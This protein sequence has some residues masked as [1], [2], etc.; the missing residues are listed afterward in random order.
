MNR[1]GASG[2]VISP[3][4]VETVTVLPFLALTSLIFDIVLLFSSSTQHSATV[5]LFLSI[6]EIVPCF[7]SPAA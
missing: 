3:P 4:S 5:R 7:N 1:S 2:T 6:K